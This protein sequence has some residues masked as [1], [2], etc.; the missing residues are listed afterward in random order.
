[1]NLK[2]IF[3]ICGA[4]I[5]VGGANG[6]F[7]GGGGMICVPLLLLLGLD[8]QH[9]QATA[10]MVM[11]PVSLVSVVVYLIGNKVVF[12]P[13]IYVGLG[14]ICGGLL[15]AFLLSKLS[16]KVL[17]FIFVFVVLGVGIRMLF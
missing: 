17:Q 8:N 9:A 1:M 5:L 11:L 2:K 6:L 15:G 7:G 14:S 16:N 3:L 13:T 4:G 12:D 10:I